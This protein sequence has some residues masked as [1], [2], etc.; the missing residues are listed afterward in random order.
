MILR[1]AE[2]DENYR[3]IGFVPDVVRMTL[4]VGCIEVNAVDYP[5]G[6]IALFFSGVRPDTAAQFEIHLP[7]D[8][9]AEMVAGMIYVNVVRIFPEDAP[10]QGNSRVI[11]ARGLERTHGDTAAAS[12]RSAHRG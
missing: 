9:S 3:R 6:G 5:L 7:V 11:V 1:T 12:H 8:C 2:A 4:K 10:N